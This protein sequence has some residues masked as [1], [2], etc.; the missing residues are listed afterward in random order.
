MVSHRKQKRADVQ[1]SVVAYLNFMISSPHTG[2]L[3]QSVF[4]LL[5]TADWFNLKGNKFSNVEAGTALHF[6]VYQMHNWREVETIQWPTETV[7]T[8]VPTE[9]RFFHGLKK[10]DLSN[11][12]LAG[13]GLML[14]LFACVEECGLVYDSDHQLSYLLTAE[15]HYQDP[16]QTSACAPPSR[17]WV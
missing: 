16:S 11:K 5:G 7:F 2:D 12:G 14:V 15:R 17:V 3:P 13:V 1:M 4:K 10:L 6:L 8:T 9:I